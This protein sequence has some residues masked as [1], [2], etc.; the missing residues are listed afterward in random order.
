MESLDIVQDTVLAAMA[1]DYPQDRIRVIVTDD[2]ASAEVR[3]WV[4]ALAICNLHYTARVKEG[5]AGY[6]AGN[7]NHAIDFIKT[8]PGGP[9]DYIAGLDADM[10]PEK[11]WLRSV[12]PHLLLDPKLGVATPR[13][14]FYNIP[15]GDPLFQNNQI[16][17][18][19]TDG[20][21]DSLHCVW[22]S[23]S[24]YV[25]RRTALEDI[26]GF[27]LGSVTEDVFSSML[28]LSKGWKSAYLAEAL[29]F[30]LVPNSY[31]GHIKQ[32]V[33]WVSSSD[34]S[35][36]LCLDL[37][38]SLNFKQRLSG[39]W[40]LPN[41]YRHILD[42]V[43][44]VLVPIFLLDNSRSHGQVE[45][46]RRFTQISCVAG[47]T[48]F[49]HDWTRGWLIGYRTAIRES[50]LQ[51]YM[52]PYYVIAILRSFVLPHSLGG[53]EPGFKAT[54]SISDDT[55]ERN[56]SQRAPLTRRAKHMIMGCGVWVHVFLIVYYLSY[57]V[58]HTRRIILQ[59]TTPPEGGFDA[60]S[61]PLLWMEAAWLAPRSFKV[62]ATCLTP[63]RYMFAPPNDPPR[64]DLM[65]EREETTGARYP[66]DA[67]RKLWWSSWNCWNLFDFEIL[68]FA[69]AT[70]DVWLL[71][72]TW[73]V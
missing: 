27:A 6:K 19:I 22:N 8:L 24:G 49:L 10:I 15:T 32:Q 37:E 55:H 73:G 62:L 1:V 41:A 53:T 66:K 29:Q 51:L 47:L 71:V 18:A 4:E 28:K 3:A 67:A 50:G 26:G 35:I 12:L 48:H 52:A 57:T 7:L 68:Y 72:K 69:I 17:W 2:G 39:F 5:S 44:L 34:H 65:A 33:R 25:M 60:S 56:A 45:M 46:L 14:C 59:A 43:D 20:F 64:G 9:A 23:G 70:F 54:G 38:K 36:N 30:G 13:Q 21:R 42:T 31:L 58:W 61:S 63:V 16:S 40:N 11:R